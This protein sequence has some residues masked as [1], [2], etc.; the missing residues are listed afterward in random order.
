[1]N[2]LSLNFQANYGYNK[3]ASYRQKYLIPKQETAISQDTVSFK[4]AGLMF[5]DALEKS[6][7]HRMER[8]EREATRFK[9]ILESVA[10][11]LSKHGVSFIRSYNEKNCVKSPKSVVSKVKRAKTFIL[12]DRIRATLFC[13][14]LYDLSVLND[15]ILP[16]LK[17]RGYIVNESEI[18]IE[19]LK[20]RGFVPIGEDENKS[21]ILMPDIDI[22]LA[23]VK[24]QIDKLDDKYAFTISAPQKSGYEDIQIRF[25]NIDD[26]RKNPTPHELIL[27]FGKNYAREKHYDSEKIYSVTREFKNLNIWQRKSSNTDIHLEKVKR[28]I[29]LISKTLS[30]EIT[31]KAYENAKNMD[32]YGIENP[33][34]I[35]MQSKDI[36]L[37]FGIENKKD[38]KNYYDEII[39]NINLYYN[40]AIETQKK[41]KNDGIVLK[42]QRERKADLEKLKDIK[43]GLIEAIDFY[44]KGK[45]LKPIRELEVK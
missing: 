35:K 39:N 41:F 23:D 1:M 31:S 22:R 13:N 25:I 34:P 20:L 32:V 9:D 15:Y 42:L 29:D 18:P 12:P 28:Y 26:K 17:K 30:S 24:S 37:L 7:E 21:E 14:Q 5:Q 44:N 40:K 27:L 19:D 10:S 2:I 43:K 16:E 36:E 11:T 4:R 45:N 6:A 38:S 33:L 8:L 3:P